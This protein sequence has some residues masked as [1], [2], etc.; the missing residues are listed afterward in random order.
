MGDCARK[1][2]KESE[3]A[4]S[5]FRT[6]PLFQFV[7][8][9]LE[10]SHKSYNLVVMI[11]V[12]YVTLWLPTTMVEILSTRVGMFGLVF[13]ERMASPVGLLRHVPYFPLIFLHYLFF[14]ATTILHA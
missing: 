12:N 14:V 8:A 5:Y 13:L 2:E 4:C 11:H 9:K 1:H 7:G 6:P 10:V 3:I